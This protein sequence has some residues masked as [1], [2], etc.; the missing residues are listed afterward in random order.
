MSE[1]GIFLITHS[2]THRPFAAAASVARARMIMF[3]D[4]EPVAAMIRITL[5]RGR[6]M[7]MDGENSQ[8]RSA[9]GGPKC[10]PLLKWLYAADL[11]RLMVVSHSSCGISPAEGEMQM[12]PR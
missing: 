3:R 11:Q 4:A 12:V 5:L 1:L 10:L 2:H 7:Q 8:E 6:T 9:T